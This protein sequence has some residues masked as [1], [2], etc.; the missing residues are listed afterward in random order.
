MNKVYVRYTDNK[1][2]D[3]R[4][5]RSRAG[6]NIGHAEV[7]YNYIREEY[8]DE[9]KSRVPVQILDVY[10]V[11]KG[12]EES[13]NSQWRS[14]I[15]TGKGTSLMEST[16][17]EYRRYLDPTTGEWKQVSGYHLLNEELVQTV[18]KGAIAYA[19]RSIM[20]PEAM[21]AYLRAYRAFGGKYSIIGN[22]CQTFANDMFRFATSGRIPKVLEPYKHF[23][24]YDYI[25]TI[26]GRINIL[27]ETESLKFELFESLLQ[28]VK[29]YEVW[30][31]IGRN[32]LERIKAPEVKYNLE[33]P[34][35]E[36]TSLLP[37]SDV[38]YDERFPDQSLSS[39]ATE[40]VVN[41]VAETQLAERLKGI[42]LKH[43]LTN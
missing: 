15:I 20:D 17:T 21:N 6:L 9:V 35:N 13:L 12:R 22:N 4:D 41:L 25:K 11:A 24:S 37:G 3:S 28:G 36:S 5:L 23:I 43:D 29:G 39:R 31:K 26:E 8:V 10:A 14:Q 42:F 34:L 32:R 18:T 40:A 38:P 1:D 30:Q 2:I 7:V 19:G 33:V 16:I 27:T